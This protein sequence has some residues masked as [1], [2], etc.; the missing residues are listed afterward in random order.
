M[1]NKACY[2]IL[3][4]PI[5]ISAHSGIYGS[6]F[7]KIIGPSIFDAIS[8]QEEVEIS[9][10]GDIS[11]LRDNRRNQEEH[12]AILS[13]KDRDGVQQQWEIELSIRGKYRRMFS[14]GVPPL[15][16][17]FKKKVL[18]ENGLT[19]HNDLKLVTLFHEDKKEA[20]QTLIKEY[21]A[22]K[23]YNLITDDSYRVQLVKISYKDTSTG[24]TSKEHGFLIEDTAQLLDRIGAEKIPDSVAIDQSQLHPVQQHL[25]ALYQYMIG[26]GDWNFHIPKNLRYCDKKG[27][28]YAIPFDFDFCGMVDASYAVPNN[29]Y[30]IR[31]VR[32][33]I[34]LGLQDSI[35]YIRP[36]YRMFDNNKDEILEMVKNCK[37][38]NRENKNKATAYL[39]SFFKEMDQR[40]EHNIPM[41]IKVED[42]LTTK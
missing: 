5:F 37:K 3:F 40:I 26:N 20:Y 6:D 38:L 24:K 30:N 15:K 31:S 36:V 29:V 19:D 8:Y 25:V 10:E 23:I 32:D 1:I 4:I 21:L 33:R 16:L 12:D 14:E 41:S 39:Q 28:V 42:Y 27:T 9:I 13:F 7:T 17:D 34:Y 22:Y 18:K 35:S 11:F 2:I